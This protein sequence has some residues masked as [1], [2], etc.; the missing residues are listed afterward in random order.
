MAL[1]PENQ[2]SRYRRL[3]KGVIWRVVA[4]GALFIVGVMIVSDVRGTHYWMCE[5]CGTIKRQNTCQLGAIKIPVGPQLIQ[6]SPLAGWI[7]QHQG[8]HIHRWKWY[9]LRHQDILGNTAGWSCGREPAIMR[10]AGND[11][12]RTYLKAA[13]EEEVGELVRILTEGNE[14]E[15]EKAVEIADKRLLEYLDRPHTCP[16]CTQ[17]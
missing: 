5:T 14:E 2:P 15:Q 13:T 17:P 7:V 12:Q 9:H 8:S 1:T 3:R 10:L 4:I 11:T 6:E 16:S